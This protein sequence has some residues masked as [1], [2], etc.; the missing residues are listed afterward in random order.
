MK[1][2]YKM[3]SL[4]HFQHWSLNIIKRLD[5]ELTDGRRIYGNRQGRDCTIYLSRFHFLFWESLEYLQK[6][7]KTKNRVILS[8]SF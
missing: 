2:R 5:R 6:T 3:L 4:S 1:K 7:G 8:V